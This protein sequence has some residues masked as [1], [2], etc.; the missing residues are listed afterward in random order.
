V[1]ALHIIAC[2]GG[3]NTVSDVVESERN[4]QRKEG[5]RD[6]KNTTVLVVILL[7]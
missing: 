3:N 6:L 2:D 4:E 1:P 5:R 7:S